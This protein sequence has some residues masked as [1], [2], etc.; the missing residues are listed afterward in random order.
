MLTDFSFLALTFLSFPA[1]LHLY[2][3]SIVGR[4][5][6]ICHNSILFSLTGKKCRF[7]RKEA[8]ATRDEEAK[9]TRK[10]MRMTTDC[11]G[12]T[13]HPMINTKRAHHRAP[14]EFSKEE[15]ELIFFQESKSWENNH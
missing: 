6:H 15:K 2:A 3:Y 9:T 8:K 13:L 14:N 11:Q 4:S 10:S 1:C 7:W 5:S 12:E